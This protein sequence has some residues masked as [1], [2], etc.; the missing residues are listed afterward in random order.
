M[1]NSGRT[2][3]LGVKKDFDIQFVHY[4]GAANH[5]FKHTFKG[6]IVSNIF[7]Y[8]FKSQNFHMQK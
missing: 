5:L 8:V 6:N 3:D 2:V 7:Q 1:K 4:L